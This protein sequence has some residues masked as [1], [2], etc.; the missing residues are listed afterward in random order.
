MDKKVKQLKNSDS[1]MVFFFK[2]LFIY[3]FERER[4]NK[5]W[6]RAERER[7]RSRLPVNILGF[8]GHRSLLQHLNSAV[9]M[10]QC[11]EESVVVSNKIVFTKIALGGF[12]V[13]C[14]QLKV[15]LSFL[16]QLQEAQDQHAEAVRCIEK[17]KDHIQ[18]YN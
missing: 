15:F 11:V 3:L 4:E 18:I 12:I 10:N 8:V 7:E 6:G 17:S 1:Q 9:V 14:Q 13:D 2:I 5:Q 16:F